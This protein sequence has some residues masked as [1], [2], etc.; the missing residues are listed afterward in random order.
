[1]HPAKLLSSLI[2]SALLGWTGP[3]LVHVSLAAFTSPIEVRH[4]TL[5]EAED[6]FE[7]ES[8]KKQLHKIERLGKANEVVFWDDLHASLAATGAPQIALVESVLAD[9]T[10]DRAQLSLVP[11]FPSHDPQLYPP[12]PKRRNVREGTGTWKRVAK[13]LGETMSDAE[14]L[15]MIERADT[16]QDGEISPDEFYAIMTKK[17][18][19]E[20]RP[21]AR[22]PAHPPAHPRPSAA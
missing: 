14:L 15:E 19:G 10:T 2:G 16:D 5:D 3:P 18:F 13:E 20:S 17:T 11:N 7:V 9:F 12:G 4:A 8:F 1:M 22:P 6:P 21:P